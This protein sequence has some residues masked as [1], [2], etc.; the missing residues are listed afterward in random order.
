MTPT[1]TILANVNTFQPQ[2]F[3]CNENIRP[4]TTASYFPPFSW[5]LQPQFQQIYFL[6]RHQQKI[7]QQCQH[8]I[9]ITTSDATTTAPP[10][11]MA[12]Y[13]FRLSWQFRQQFQ[14]QHLLQTSPTRTISTNVKT[15]AENCRLHHQ[16]ES[17]TIP[18]FFLQ[19]KIQIPM[20]QATRER[21]PHL[22][23]SKY[24]MFTA[25][26]SSLVLS[27]V[28]LLVL[29]PGGLS[30]SQASEYIPKPGSAL[31]PP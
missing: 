8:T 7:F 10:S 23:L 18:G 9:T 15:L 29:L 4:T 31:Q 24:S 21:D 20:S 6:Q 13:F 3:D 30:L 25:H 12:S 28:A 17:T 5:Q 27:G 2:Q 14:Q 22:S 11:T 16:H 19:I 26:S 1:K